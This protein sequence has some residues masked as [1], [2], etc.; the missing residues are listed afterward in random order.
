MQNTNFNYGFNQ[1]PNQQPQINTNSNAQK[2]DGFLRS[3]FFQHNPELQNLQYRRTC[4]RDWDT[5][6]A[7]INHV[8]AMEATRG[9]T[10]KE[11]ET[12]FLCKWFLKTNNEGRSE[13]VNSEYNRPWNTSS[14]YVQTGGS[15]KTSTGYGSS[16][17][18]NDNR[19][20]GP[21]YSNDNRSSASMYDNDSKRGMF[22]SGYT[23]Q[24]SGS[25]NTPQASA[26]GTPTP[27][28]QTS[29]VGTNFTAQPTSGFGTNTTPQSNSG[30][31]TNYTTPQ[32]AMFSGHSTA[33]PLQ[34]AFA[35][36]NNTAQR[37]VYGIT[38]GSSLGGQSQNT[39]GAFV[40]N[41]MPSQPAQQRSSF[42]S[43]APISLSSIFGTTPTQFESTNKNGQN[44]GTIGNRL[45]APISTPVSG[46]LSDFMK[47]TQVS[48][49][50]SQPWSLNTS[51]NMAPNTAN[52]FM[53]TNIGSTQG[54]L[55]NTQQ[56]NQ[57]TG[58]SPF[59]ARPQELKQPLQS[60]STLNQ[61][62]I[63]NP[64]QPTPQQS[65]FMSA[66]SNIQQHTA[67]K[68]END[69]F[70]PTSAFKTPSSF[71]IQPP[72]S[73][74]NI[75]PTTA[76]N[77][78]HTTSTHNQIDEEESDKESHVETSTISPP[79]RI[80]EYYFNDPKFY[81][82]CNTTKIGKKLMEPGFL[83]FPEVKEQSVIKLKLEIWPETK[84][85][86]ES[87]DFSMPSSKRQK[88][89][90]N[91]EDEYTEKNPEVSYTRDFLSESQQHLL[92][93]GWKQPDEE[94]NQEDH[95]EENLNNEKTEP[96]VITEVT[97]MNTSAS[98][99]VHTLTEQGIKNDE[100]D[101]IQMFP[102]PTL[103]SGNSLIFNAKVVF[104]NSLVIKYYEPVKSKDFT[105]ANVREKIKLDFLKPSSRNNLKSLK[106]IKLPV[107]SDPPGVG[108]N[109][110]CYCK[111]FGVSPINM[112]DMEKLET[113]K[114][115]VRFSRF[116]Q[117]LHKVLDK[118][119]VKYDWT[120][121]GGCLE[122]VFK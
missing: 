5:K 53:S 113:H 40:L 54:S 1:S 57:Y 12:M 61:T 119:F 52:T 71:N 41:G 46:D 91:T 13:Q 64:S 55:I 94:V 84:A 68:S 67:I 95:Q 76:Q 27:S 105:V 117:Y 51:S 18:G 111:V 98:E 81:K 118:S 19:G 48:P 93:K 108:L 25:L 122:M 23:N 3:H 50:Q 77:I 30:I 120:S 103:F 17:Y 107:F 70:Q 85:F 8:S 66:P 100:E 74:N 14:P 73:H 83:M 24:F 110:A 56:E 79:S 75:Q 114:D 60:L 28:Q 10:P 47:R 20:N 115:V 90:I 31:G 99:T 63:I 39:S 16:M 9:F 32:T 2:V 89:T 35:T 72:S 38:S 62:H 101:E 36:T 106:H 7:Y 34:S 121:N 4:Y 45:Q 26:F 15:F 6:T 49:T 22:S 116:K 58:P 86:L 88:I 33:L 44:V 65:S 96:D 69:S 37:P 102:N 43:S 42:V 82:F 92:D 21:M 80:D 97:N 112:E 87:K 109:K 104:R 29:G 11:I 59:L 78:T